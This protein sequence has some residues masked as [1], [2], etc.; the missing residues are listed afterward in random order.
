[1]LFSC[2]G[3]EM[4]NLTEAELFNNISASCVTKHTVQA[5]M[6]ELHRIK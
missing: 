1:M 5:R 2:L 3:Q 4:M 6:T